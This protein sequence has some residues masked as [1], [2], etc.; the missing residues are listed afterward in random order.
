MPVAGGDMKNLTPDWDLIPDAA[1]WNRDYVYFGAAVGGDTHL[2]RVPAG[3][4]RVERITQGDRSLGSFSFSEAFDRVAYTATDAMHPAEV[5]VAGTDGRGEVKRSA[6]NQPWLNDV[7]LSAAE[8]IRFHSQD[9]AEVEGWVVLP[10]T[11]T[12]PFPLV[13][14]MHGGPHGAYG[15]HFDFEFQLLASNGYAVLFTNP[16]GS[17]G[18]GE[19]FLWA[20]WG[21]WGKLDYQDV[22]AGVDYALGHYPL[23][24][25]RLGVTGYSYGGFL[26]NWVITQTDRFRAA[27]AGAGVSNW[28][29]DY[30]TADIP[31]TK[32]T[33]IFGAP[34]DQEASERMR[35]LSP[36]T[37]AGNVRTP[38][39]FLDGE[40]D[41]RV[42]ISQPEEMYTALKTRRVP[43]KMVRYPGD[44]HGGW[45]PWDMVHRYYQELQW[46]RQYL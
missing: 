11:S 40:A 8:R 32:E 33:E 4:G 25:K 30:G 45:P 1:T 12:G 24:A 38:T 7:Q 41:M 20:T 39:L 15:N 2:F 43:A 36:I 22:M 46:W 29:S 16:R 3:G 31:R 23:D 6:L 17:T 42:P 44:Y 18:Y 34:W 19:K 35:A 27:I 28:L 14:C 10:R 13:L 5:F 21:G 9:G 37:H 26:T